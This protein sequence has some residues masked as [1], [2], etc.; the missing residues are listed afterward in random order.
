MKTLVCAVSFYHGEVLWASSKQPWTTVTITHDT[1]RPYAFTLWWDNFSRNTCVI[2][3]KNP[4]VSILLYFPPILF[5]FFLS[6]LGFI[7]S[8]A[9]L[10]SI[11]LSSYAFSRPLRPLRPLRQL[12]GFAPLAYSLHGFWLVHC[13][14]PICCHGP[15]VRNRWFHDSQLQPSHCSVFV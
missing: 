7:Q 10:R 3:L 5:R 9:K 8:E 4:G 11:A 12:S 6:F 2:L 1:L 15:D 14:L 13:V